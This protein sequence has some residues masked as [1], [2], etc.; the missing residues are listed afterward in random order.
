MRLKMAFYFLWSTA[1]SCVLLI[2]N[3]CISAVCVVNIIII[4]VAQFRQH[5]AFLK[6]TKII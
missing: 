1:T 3:K 4:H 2:N 6:L 5:R